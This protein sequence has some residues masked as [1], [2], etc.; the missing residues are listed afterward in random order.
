MIE[1]YRGNIVCPNKQVDKLE[2]FYSGHLLESETYIGGHVECLEAG[3]FRADIPAKFSLVPSALQQLIDHIDRDLTFALE[4]EHGI[5][6]SEALNYDEVRQAIVEKLE[7]LRDS[8]HREEP[9]IIYH[10]DVGAMYPNIILTNRLQPSAMVSNAEC[11]ACD[12]NR[13]ENA[14][15]RPM[16]WTWRGEYNPAR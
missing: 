8:P 1:A 5:Q 12:F 15:K 3:V 2:S 7:M 10:L 9:P 16:T 13:A 14:C 4:V 11:A 6:R